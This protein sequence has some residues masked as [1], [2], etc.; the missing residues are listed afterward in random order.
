[1]KQLAGAA[2]LGLVLAV[3]VFSPGS[4]QGAAGTPPPWAY[5]VN[6]PA[7]PAAAPRDDE[8]LRRVPGSDVAFTLAQTRDAFNVP[9]WRPEGHPPMPAVVS[10]GRKP[11]LRACGYCHL[12]NG[13]GRPEN[14]GLAGQPAAYIV[15]QML[16]YRNGLRKSSEPRMGPPAAMLAVA[17]AATDE[18]IRVAADYF[19]AIVPKPWIR[20]VETDTVP[21]TRVA[22]SMY[23]P[24]DE[25]GTEPIGS[26]IVEV[27][28][29]R[30]RTELRDAASGFVAYV[31]AGSTARGE[32]LV[33]T[34]GSGKTI[35][36]AI[37]HGDDLK[38]I[39]PVPGIAGRSPSYTVRQLYDMQY[40]SR[41][42]L[43]AALM[44]ATVAKLT[45]DDLVAIAA[46]TASRVP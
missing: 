14:A 29:D 38:G 37:C 44:R 24:I 15:Q 28:E 30:G 27:P 5:P 8:G 26:R 25:G 12:P 23:V 16:D 17:K 18:D 19:A 45:E 7:A 40:G 43:G 20:V 41:Q 36:C 13:F 1:M 39:G 32:A 22:G 2:A 35:R 10:Q 33:T 4:I 11:S 46:Y 42:G 21:K 31:P 34:G 3:A 6:P 9:D